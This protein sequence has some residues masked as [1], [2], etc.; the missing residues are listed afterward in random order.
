MNFSPPAQKSRAMTTHPSSSRALAAALREK[1]LT[2][3]VHEGAAL[4]SEREIVDQTGLG[5]SSVREALRELEAEGLIITRTGRNGGA[6]ARRPDED[7]LARFVS[8]FVRGRSVPIEVL[9]EARTTL[10]PSLAF[11][12]AVNRTDDDAVALA[13]ACSAMEAATDGMSFGRLNVAWHYCVANAS[14]NELLVAF[15]TSISAAIARSS[16][17]HARVFETDFSEI[18][19]AVVRAHRGVTDA[20]LRGQPEAAKR[21]MERHLTAYTETLA[22]VASAG[23]SG[24]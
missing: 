7:G 18:R 6:F 9:L 11:L 3:D 5:R 4:P 16:Q 21:R 24:S 12:A 17:A 23:A 10:E 8:L 19:A 14:H 22:R 13:D 1:I 15:L 2:G 20:V